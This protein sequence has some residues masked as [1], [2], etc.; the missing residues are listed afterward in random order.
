MRFEDAYPW[1]SSRTIRLD[2]QFSSPDSIMRDI[3][4]P[5]A[6]SVSAC[7]FAAF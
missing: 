4:D 6:N 2:A 3:D 7:F 1:G 5:M